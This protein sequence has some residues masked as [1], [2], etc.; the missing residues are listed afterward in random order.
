MLVAIVVFAC[1][2]V[3]VVCGGYGCEGEGTMI[4]FFANHVILVCLLRFE[5]RRHHEKH[6]AATL[7]HRCR[8]I[9][10]AILF[11]ISFFVVWSALFS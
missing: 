5:L 1:D 9:T 8:H 3:C 7:H 10:L 11:L 4:I 6:T 2:F